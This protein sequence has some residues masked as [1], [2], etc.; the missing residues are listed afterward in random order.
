MSLLWKDMIF[1]E[2]ISQI[3]YW[4]FW[5]NDRTPLLPQTLNHGRGSSSVFNHIHRYWRLFSQ[6]ICLI[7]VQHKKKNL[8]KHTRKAFW[9]R[10]LLDKRN[11]SSVS[12][13]NNGSVL[14]ET[15]AMGSD[16]L[17][18]RKHSWHSIALYNIS[19]FFFNRT[20]AAYRLCVYKAVQQQQLRKKR[21]KKKSWGKWNKNMT[22]VWALYCHPTCAVDTPCYDQEGGAPVPQ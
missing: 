15:S 5:S 2:F 21:E 18:S 10:S 11:T 1:H 14:V 20:D 4:F 13:C 22:C 6:Q 16:T 19:L 7:L 8:L 17:Q 12:V 3:A 9:N